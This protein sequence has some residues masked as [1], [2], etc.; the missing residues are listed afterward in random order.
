MTLGAMPVVAAV[1]GNDSFGAVLAARD[2]AA[3]R[4]CAAALD[5]GHHLRLVEAD[6]ANRERIPRHCG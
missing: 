1:I 6:V 4:D 2:M 5:G 3:E